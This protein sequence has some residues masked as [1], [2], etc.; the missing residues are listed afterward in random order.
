MLNLHGIFPPVATPFTERG[1]LDLDAL[2]FNAHRWMQTRLRGL[3]VL[4]TNGEAAYLDGDESEAVVAAARA[5]MPADRTLVAGTGHDA[6][7]QT[8]RACERAAKAGADAVLV[9]TPGAFKGLMTGEAF[10]RH[11]RAVADASPVPVLLYNF[12]N[13]FGVNMPTS[14]IVALAEHPNIVGMK[15]SGG[16]ISQI[17]EQ[18]GATPA[19]FEVV[20]GSAPSLYASLCVGAVGGVVALANVAPD[21]CVALYDH[22]VA[23]RHAEALAQQRA[24]TPLAVAVTG[25]HGVPGLKAAMTLAGYRG[26]FP[27]SPLA[28]AP[29]AVVDDLRA[30]IDR[31]HA[32]P[33]LA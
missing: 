16:D 24:I 3:V 1:D 33:G 31:L 32:A 15:E 27:R 4:G 23:G 12:A 10:V 8:I 7:R 26:G 21:A 11:F 20:V 25:K 6:T 29:Q 5:C 22:A 17:N 13:N 2:Q 19:R 9:R 28:P 14:A 30:T 18:V